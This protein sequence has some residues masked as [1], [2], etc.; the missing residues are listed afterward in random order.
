MS[1]RLART[2]GRMRSPARAGST[3]SPI[4]TGAPKQ[5]HQDGLG[6]I[7]GMM[8]GRDDPMGATAAL[9]RGHPSKCRS[10]RVV[11]SVA[12]RAIRLE[13]GRD[14]DPRRGEGHPELR[15]SAAPGRAHRPPPRAGRDRLRAPSDAHPESRGELGQ[16]V[17]QRHRIGTAETATSTTSPRASR[18]S[19]RSCARRA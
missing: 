2:K 13:P 19:S 11:T 15:Q 5:A 16:D 3:A 18:P 6:A 17:E 10:E 14:L 8:T 7:I 4:G 9:A 12:S 1:V